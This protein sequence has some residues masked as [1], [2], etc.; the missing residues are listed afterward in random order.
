MNNKIRVVIAYIFI[1]PI[2]NLNIFCSHNDEIPLDKTNIPFHWVQLKNEN[3]EWEYYIPCPSDT[4]EI[5]YSIDMDTIGKNLLLK[6]NASCPYKISHDY[7]Y[8]VTKI[9]KQADSLTFQTRSTEDTTRFDVISFKYMDKS[10]DFGRWSIYLSLTKK[11][12]VIDNCI[13]LSDTIKY[14]RVV[15]PCDYY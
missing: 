15:E 10:K 11:Y 2:S 12:F 7:R 9:I 8:V 13:P 1:F 14:K 5:Y 6:L 3:N 4:N